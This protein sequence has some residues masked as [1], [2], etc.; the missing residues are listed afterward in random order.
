[1]LCDSHACNRAFITGNFNI[2]PQQTFTKIDKRIQH[3]GK[4][5]ADGVSVSRQ[6]CVGVGAIA[7][8]LIA[9]LGLIIGTSYPRY[10]ILEELYVYGEDL[11]LIACD[12]PSVND[13]FWVENRELHIEEEGFQRFLAEE[14]VAGEYVYVSFGTVMK[15]PGYGGCGDVVMVS[16]KDSSD[17]LNL[18]ADTIGNRISEILLKWI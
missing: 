3:I 9:A 1:M 12:T 6:M 8:L 15:L 5:R 17:I 4:R 7:I 2:L 14:D 10:T 13:A 18:A 16:V 11:E